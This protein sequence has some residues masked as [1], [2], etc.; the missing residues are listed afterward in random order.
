MDERT[1]DRVDR[2]FARLVALYGHRFTA[3]ID[4]DELWAM[5][6]EEWAP[7]AAALTDEQIRRAL[8]ACKA[9]LDAWPPPIGEFVR[10]A[11]GLPEPHQA[12]ARAAKG[13]GD[14]LSRLIRRESG[15]PYNVR[16]ADSRTAQRLCER[17]YEG[18]A[19][20]FAE[21]VNRGEAVEASTA[22]RAALAA[23]AEH[24]AVGADRRNGSG[25]LQQL[26][27]YEVPL[28]HEARSTN[29]S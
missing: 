5:A 11:L 8:E 9:R 26:G 18:I 2:V 15:D 6:R 3:P 12:A 22:I 14:T 27:P 25:E 17:A 28:M 19:R 4:T 16:M 1:A 29:A 20:G 24:A 23:P 10:L 7:A 13:E 21:R